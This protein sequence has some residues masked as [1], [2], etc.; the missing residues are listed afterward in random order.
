MEFE[1][2]AGKAPTYTNESASIA[3][4]RFIFPRTW[5]TCILVVAIVMFR[6][7]PISLAH[8]DGNQWRDIVLCRSTFV[9]V[10]RGDTIV[11]IGW[12]AKAVDAR[13]IT[14]Q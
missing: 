6:L 14:P 3:A 7:R 13:A 2:A 10:A 1:R 12:L 4:P 5:W 9:S 11:T 8:A